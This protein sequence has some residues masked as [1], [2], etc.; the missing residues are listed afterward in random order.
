MLVHFGQ[1]PYAPAPAMIAVLEKHRQV[2]LNKIDDVTLD[3][4]IGITETLRPRVLRSLKVLGFIDDEGVPTAEFA[5]LPGLSDADYMPFLADMLVDAYAPVLEDIGD[6]DMGDADAVEA[7]FRSF[8]PTGQIK[9]M[10]NL[11]LGLMSYA[12]VI[13]EGPRKR[14]GKSPSAPASAR[15]VRTPKQ[16][17]LPVVD[18]TPIS[19]VTVTPTNA[20]TQTVTLRSGGTVTLGYDASLFDL[21]DDDREFVLDLVLKVKNY[22]NLR[23]VKGGT[24]AIEGGE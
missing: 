9:R 21:D 20:T 5:K 8:T 15:T 19:E 10:V 12:G 2:R 24:L 6:K 14:G 11:Y 16:K 17:S 3:L 23:P 1:A 7:A 22:E 18:P 4:R 13:T